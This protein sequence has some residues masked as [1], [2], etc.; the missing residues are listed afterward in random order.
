M[1]ST[2][3]FLTDSSSPKSRR[4]G[5]NENLAPVAARNV[6]GRPRRRPP[7]P[8]P[9]KKSNANLLHIC[10]IR[11]L[12]IRGSFFP[13]SRAAARNTHVPPAREVLFGKSRALADHRINGMNTV[14]EIITLYKNDA[15]SYVKIGLTKPKCAFIESMIKLMA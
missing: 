6:A 8:A 14:P 12:P 13:R 2:E 5:D 15:V 11:P 3:S 9:T 7:R 1:V 4:I 10:S